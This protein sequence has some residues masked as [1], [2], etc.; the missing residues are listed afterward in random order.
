M[1]RQRVIKWCHTA[2]SG[3]QRMTV[4]VD[5]EYSRRQNSTLQRLSSHSTWQKRD[6]G[7]MA[8]DLGLS[9][10]TSQRVVVDILQHFSHCARRLC[11]AVTENKAASV[12]PV[13]VSCNIL[14]QRNDIRLCWL[15]TGETWVRLSTP[16]AKQSN[17]LRKNSKSPTRREKVLTAVLWKPLCVFGGGLYGISTPN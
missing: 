9:F 4:E 2:A 12:V 1:S 7:L 3:K 16:T 13:S 17:M 8:S 15:V 10:N 11:L 5:D 14:M 6:L